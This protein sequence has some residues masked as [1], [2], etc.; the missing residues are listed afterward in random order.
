L[1]VDTDG[2]I[3]TQPVEPVVGDYRLFYTGVRDAVLGTGKPPVAGIEA[4][5]TARVLEWALESAKANRNIECNW[6]REPE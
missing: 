2:S 1:A 6:N 5:R 3:V 4:W